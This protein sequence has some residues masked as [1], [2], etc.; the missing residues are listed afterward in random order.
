VWYNVNVLNFL[1]NRQLTYYEN[2]SR[3]VEGIASG[4]YSKFSVE[5]SEFQDMRIPFGIPAGPLL[6]SRYCAVAFNAGYDICTY[7]TVRAGSQRVND[8]PNILFVHPKQ[9]ELHFAEA[10]CGVLADTTPSEPLNIS[11]S[12]GVPSFD[13][14][15]WQP[16]MQLALDSRK[17]GQ[18]LVGSFQGLD[19]SIKSFVDA[20][21]LI[22]ETGVK[23]LELNT[24]CPNEGTSSLLCFNPKLVAKITEEVKE[25]VGDVP[26]LIKIAYLN[27]AGTDEI[28]EN[29]LEE[30]VSETV[31]KGRVQGIVA[32]NTIP[33]KLVNSSGQNALTGGR[34]TSGVCGSSIKW[35]GLA[36]T[37]RLKAISRRIQD[38]I[39]AGFRIVGVGGVS[40]PDD[41]FD[42]LN[43]GADEV[44]AATGPM[45]NAGLAYEIKRRIVH[46]KERVVSGV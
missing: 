2:Y 10:E 42:Y 39:G 12:F 33:S 20:A 44:M 27:R 46:D 23:V 7:K 26:L 45:Y 5:T 9:P 4:W 18:Q 3:N 28:D 13:P 15:I 6:N 38:N 21:K 34:Q 11:N 29:L 36:M 30:L 43:A 17:Y 8:F 1:Y 14:D 35:A 32:I 24:S 31:L 16:D 41:Y 19:G 37:A 40:S 22:V 25:A